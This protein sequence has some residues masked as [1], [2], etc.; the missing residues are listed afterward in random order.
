M[1]VLM[2]SQILD[3]NRDKPDQ[4]RRS[5][6]DVT[7]L[8]VNV[9]LGDFHEVI[10]V[11]GTL[12]QLVRRGTQLISRAVIQR[13]QHLPCKMPDGPVQEYGRH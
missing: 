12:L 10:G 13:N 7:P 11:T 3:G 5:T 6:F 9:L 8:A 4:E 1:H 2:L